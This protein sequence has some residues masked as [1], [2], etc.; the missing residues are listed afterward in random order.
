M[1]HR[2]LNI[3]VSHRKFISMIK[4][5]TATLP[6]TAAEPAKPGDPV[7]FSTPQACCDDAWEDAYRRFETPA[8]EVAKFTKRL[9]ALGAADWPKGAAMVELFCGRGNGLHA[10]TQLGFAQVEGVDLSARLIA[11]Y[12]GPARTYIGDCRDLPFPSQSKDVIIIQGGLHHLPT[13]P[14]DLDRTL[15][16]IRRVLRPTGRLVVV[17]PWLTPFLS[18][19]HFLS[20]RRLL[21]RLFPRVDAFATMVAHEQRTY[22]QWLHQP[23]L[24]LG[25]FEKHFETIKRRMGWGKLTT[26]GSPKES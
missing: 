22:D 10:L 16:Q 21:R 3:P 26:I 15:A 23:K 20:R 7:Q 8:M 18:I 19:V 1:A 14:D 11:Q 5:A 25:C 12:Q 2:E 6:T 9:L 13:L 4:P 17:E 24:V